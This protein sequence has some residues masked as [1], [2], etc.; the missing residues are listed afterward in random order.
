MCSFCGIEYKYVLSNEN[1]LTLHGAVRTVYLPTTAE[2][3]MTTLCIHKYPYAWLF[4]K[5][6]TKTHVHRAMLTVG[7]YFCM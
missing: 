5:H 1:Q 3:S 4:I 7:Q 2:A 6:L